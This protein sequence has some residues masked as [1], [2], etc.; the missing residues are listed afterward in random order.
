MPTLKKKK[1]DYE[2]Q[3]LGQLDAFSAAILKQQLASC[4]EKGGRNILVNAKQT[5]P[6]LPS[7]LE[8][9]R[10]FILHGLADYA[11]FRVTFA[12]INKR[13]LETFSI[14][15]YPA[16]ENKIIFD[17]PQYAEFY[18]GGGAIVYCKSCGAA[19][20]IQKAPQ[21]TCPFCNARFKT[22]DW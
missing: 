8:Q 11:P 18:F 22:A 10:N 2:L 20:H 15:E 3:P 14:R 5:F 4:M 16:L 19:L 6:L 1:I 12:N 9:L 7:G 21:H 13:S 17:M